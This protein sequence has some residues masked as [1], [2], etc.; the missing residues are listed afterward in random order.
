MGGKPKQK[1][2]SSSGLWQS[3][4]R[5]SVAA[6]AGIPNRR[7][8]SVLGDNGNLAGEPVR[9]NL[10]AGKLRAAEEG[11][12]LPEMPARSLEGANCEPGCDTP[13][14]NPVAGVARSSRLCVLINPI[15][16]GAVHRDLAG[17]SLELSFLAARTNPEDRS[18]PAK[19]NLL[20][21]RSLPH[22][23]GMSVSS[24]T[25]ACGHSSPRPATET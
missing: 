9:L 19:T 2:R 5:E 22:G 20:A 1:S 23:P 21:T 17:E 10:F 15:L 18:R 13:R 4:R 8:S 12:E 24:R 14:P 25:C 7:T 3:D 16:P 11:S 6:C